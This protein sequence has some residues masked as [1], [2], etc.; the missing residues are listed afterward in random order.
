MALLIASS[1]T[2][3]SA[4]KRLTDYNIMNIKS[5]EARKYLDAG[6]MYM[7]PA[8]GSVDTGAGWVQDCIDPEYGFPCKELASLLEVREPRNEDERREWGE[9]VPVD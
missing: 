8:T 5:L 7:N 6:K 3:C 2:A 9:G 1:D 4:N